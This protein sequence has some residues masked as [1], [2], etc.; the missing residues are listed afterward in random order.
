MCAG[1]HTAPEDPLPSRLSSTASTP[2][3]PTSADGVRRGITSNAASL[4]AARLAAGGLGLVGLVLA[5]RWLDEDDFG[6]LMVVVVAVGLLN[7]VTTFG[8]DDEVVRSVAR[9]SF[10]SVAAS[11]R[12]QWTIAT[13][14]V[15]AAALGAVLVDS[16]LLGWLLVGLLGLFPLA[17]TTTVTAV[18]RGLERATLLPLMACVGGAGQIVG[19][20]IAERA[21][22][23][24]GGFVVAA[25]VAQAIAAGVGAAVVLGVTRLPVAGGLRIGELAGRSWRFAAMVLASSVMIHGGVLLVALLAD[26]ASAGQHGLATRAF[27]VLR[28][29]PGAVVGALFPVMARG[30]DS[31]GWEDRRLAGLGVVLVIVGLGI[32]PGVE[33]ASGI[34][35]VAWPVRWLA[36]ALLAVVWRLAISTRLVAAD[37]EADV[38]KVALWMLPAALAALALGAWV[39]GAAGAAAASAAMIGLHTGALWRVERAGS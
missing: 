9:A 21:D 11:V 23:G 28:L 33:W 15:G 18:A 22:S 20:V 10:D 19:F 32:A 17:I 36:V 1:R 24:Y 6:R 14:I 30:G 27:E 13:V 34:D 26:E 37:R 31:D 12:L 7:L 8:T 25:V 2:P 5:A 4:F 3:S 16:G 35:G 39:A 38:L 29:I